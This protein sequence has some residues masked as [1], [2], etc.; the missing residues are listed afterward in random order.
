MVDDRLTKT[1]HF[2][3]MDLTDSL[4]KLSKLYLQE[5]VKLHGVPK[6]LVSNCDPRFTFGFLKGPQKALGIITS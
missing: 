2:L 6:S 1:M 5:I 3:A 4:E